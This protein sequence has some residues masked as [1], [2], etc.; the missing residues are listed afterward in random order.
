VPAGFTLSE[1]WSEPPPVDILGEF[2]AARYDY[3]PQTFYRIERGESWIT[4][5]GRSGD[6]GGHVRPEDV[7]DFLDVIW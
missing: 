4:I 5:D 2:V 3:Y 7:E 6:I 1:G